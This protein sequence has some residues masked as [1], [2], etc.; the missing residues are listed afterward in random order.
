MKLKSNYKFSFTNESIGIVDLMKN[1]K[2]LILF[3]DLCIPWAAKVIE[4]N[5]NIYHMEWTDN[6]S[7]PKFHHKQCYPGNSDASVHAVHLVYDGK[8]YQSIKILEEKPNIERSPL[9]KKP[10]TGNCK[11]YLWIQF[12]N[13]QMNELHTTYTYLL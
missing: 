10:A 4:R 12:S 6:E 5:I 2:I 11:V 9:R 8:H 1:K 13:E 7:L 3:Q